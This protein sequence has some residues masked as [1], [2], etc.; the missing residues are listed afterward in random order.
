MNRVFLSG[1]IRKRPE[2]AYTPKGRRVV[3]FPLWVD[4][5]AFSVEVIGSGDVFPGKVDEALGGGVLVSGELIKT[6]LKS[7]DVLRVKASKILWME[8]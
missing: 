2:V 1:K 3:T 4:E 6:R 8:E 5:G 7:R